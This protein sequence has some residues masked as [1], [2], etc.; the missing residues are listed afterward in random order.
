MPS[1]ATFPAPVPATWK[2]AKARS[3]TVARTKMETA[4]PGFNLPLD[5]LAKEPWLQLPYTLRSGA[6]PP[7]SNSDMERRTPIRWLLYCS[8]ENTV[9][10]QWY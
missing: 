3:A 10:M 2:H 7:F 6:A 9:K 8:Y 5:L 1:N 4:R